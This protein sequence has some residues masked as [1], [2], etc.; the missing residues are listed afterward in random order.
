MVD[1]ERELFFDL[2]K[3]S[4]FYAG[5]YRCVRLDHLHPNGVP[6]S[7]NICRE[8]GLTIHT[9]SQTIVE[10]QIRRPGLRHEEIAELLRSDIIKFEFVGLQCVGFN[11][12]L[13]YSITDPFEQASASTSDEVEVGFKRSHTGDFSTRSNG[14]KRR[15]RK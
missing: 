4:I 14:T 15:R 1:E 11:Y 12:E 3:N 6:Y 2:G 7:N 10:S 8:F 13:Y 9:L 5:T